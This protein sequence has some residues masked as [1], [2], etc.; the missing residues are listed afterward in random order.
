[1]KVTHNAGKSLAEEL[2]ASQKS[3]RGAQNI[4]M[5]LCSYVPASG[6]SPECWH[7]TAD[8]SIAAAKFSV[9]TVELNTLPL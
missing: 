9:F 1:M 3:F 5:L 7:Y 8:K 4:L 2:G 6:P